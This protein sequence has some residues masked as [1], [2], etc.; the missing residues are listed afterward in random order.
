MA[1]SAAHVNRSAC[2]GWHAAA[3]AGSIATGCHPDA[4]LAGMK[5]DGGTPLLAASRARVSAWLTAHPRHAEAPAS[6]FGEWAR[7]VSRFSSTQPS[8]L[9]HAVQPAELIR[10]TDSAAMADPRHTHEVE[11]DAAVA[12]QER[13]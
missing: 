13:R 4:V 2:A 11:G 5:L 1:V 9:P 10:M 12:P 7:E 6:R 8:S 3:R